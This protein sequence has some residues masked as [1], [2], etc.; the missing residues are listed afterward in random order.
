M[1][2]LATSFVLGYHGC[3]AS[4]AERLLQGE[5]FKFEKND[6]D[7]L[8]SGI[9]FWEANPARGLQF[10]R[11]LMDNPG[12]TKSVITAPA[13]VGAVIDLGLCLDLM[14]TQGIR[15]LL[16][17]HDSFVETCKRA[18]TPVP[19]NVGGKD[20][21]RRKLDCAVINHLHLIQEKTAVDKIQTVRGVFQ[22]D[23]PIYPSSGFMENTHIQICVCDKSCIKGVFRV[24]DAI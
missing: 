10:A 20:R 24:S 8:G 19:E 9:Y 22:E 4:V 1:H 15:A 2:R 18:G 14:T 12:R 17:V 21:L 13:V 23:D 7:W 11:Q 3:D 6:W 5:P 16:P